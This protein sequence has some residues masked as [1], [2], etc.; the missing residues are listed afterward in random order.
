M[1]HSDGKKNCLLLLVREKF[2]FKF[3]DFP[4]ELTSSSFVQ[5]LCQELF[6]HLEITAVLSQSSNEV[7]EK[8]SKAV[9][10]LI[11]FSQLGVEGKGVKCETNFPINGKHCQIVK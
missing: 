6:G 9:M 7:Q 3:S 5:T 1:E 11:E 10:L 8:V 4:S 2:S